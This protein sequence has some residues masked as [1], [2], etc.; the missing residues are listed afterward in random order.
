M[1][2]A[3]HHWAVCYRGFPA[4]EI[5]HDAAGFADKEYTRRDVPW[6][7]HQFPESIEPPAGHV[8]E[9][10]RRSS[11][12]PDACGLPADVDE[13]LRISIEQMMP[14]ERESRAD[15]RAGG[16]IDPLSACT[17]NALR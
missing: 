14:L 16:L 17:G 3:C 1:R 6:R 10:E 9:V 13:L 11:S 4:V 2:I 8:G 15:Q 12:T 7:K 5:R